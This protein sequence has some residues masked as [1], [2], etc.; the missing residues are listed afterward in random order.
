MVCDINNNTLFFIPHFLYNA[1]TCNKSIKTNISSH[2]DILFLEI[3]HRGTCLN[4]N[5]AT[6]RQQADVQDNETKSV[7]ANRLIFHE[8]RTLN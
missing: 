7:P 3:I 4:T 2:H 1:Q 5:G 6:L 8:I